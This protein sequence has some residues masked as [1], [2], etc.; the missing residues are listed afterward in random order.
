MIQSVLSNEFHYVPYSVE[1]KNDDDEDFTIMKVATA[2]MDDIFPIPQ[3]VI[4]IDAEQ[5]PHAPLL[6]TE[7]ASTNN[8][9]MMLL[10][11]LQL[12]PSPVEHCIYLN[13]MFR[14]CRRA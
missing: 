8:T 5:F 13:G 6:R 4:L 7:E 3:S 9:T 10:A 12:E 1:V 11:A 2:T 14:C